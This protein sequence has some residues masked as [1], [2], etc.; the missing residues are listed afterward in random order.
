MKDE[1]LK[2]LL[3]NMA[4]ESVPADVHQL[5]EQTSQQFSKTLDQ[6]GKHVHIL[7]EYAMRS[8][9][10]KLATA[11]VI[12]I[13]AVVGIT[14]LLPSQIAWADVVRPILNAT[15]AVFEIIV[16]AEDPNSTVIHDEVMGSRIRR[17]IE[18]MPNFA[19]II[20]LEEG[21]ILS[22]DKTRKEATY[23]NLQGLPSIP[24]YLDNVRNL[25]IKLQDSPDFVVEELGEK[26]VDGRRA[27][28]FRARHPKTD[29]T[30]WAD[31]ETAIP[32]RIE[33][34]EGQ[35]LIIC[36][37]MKFEV[38]LNP[39]DFSMD[40][41]KGFEESSVDLDLQGS[42]EQEFIEGLRISA[43]MSN[44]G[45]FPE[46]IGVEAYLKRAAEMA[47]KFDEM[48]LSD[49]EKTAI[50][51][52]LNR[53]LLFL[54]FFKGEGKWYYRGRGVK[55]GEAEKAIFWYRPKGSETYRV[56]YGDLHV[57]DATAEELPEPPEFEVKEPIGYQ[58]WSKSEFV[59]IQ[60]DV[61]TIMPSG[62]VEVDSQ[63]ILRKGPEDVSTMPIRLPCPSATLKSVTL[64]EQDVTFT[65]KG[66]GQYELHLPSEKLLIGNTAMMCKWTVELETLQ[67]TSY[68]FDVP[69]ES[70]VPVMEY[71]LT[72][73][74]APDCGWKFNK[75]PEETSKLLFTQQLREPK[76]V[77]GTCG[78]VIEKT[79]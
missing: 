57:E 17:T 26:E 55:L 24:N 49:K 47:R 38:P 37:H 60:E 27:V 41:P 78:F 62:D 79:N 54:R 25:I 1:H 73:A 28:G 13:V 8:R 77:F 67:K 61:W 65:A 19:S 10:K 69:L 68:G 70:L 12:L 52:K 75:T 36:R 11:A 46:E 42:T 51:M 31:R 48:D 76:D 40:V 2:D 33:Q 21:R 72:G 45:Y 44:D 3:R 7:R 30:I 58:P 22:L 43:E 16:G 39:D 74:L 6:S 20:D 56:I 15:T 50:G 5:A 32:F 71:R 59:A 14:Q 9:G 18:S 23:V 35:M 66:D 29:I 34:R 53:A 4:D 64:G 63:I